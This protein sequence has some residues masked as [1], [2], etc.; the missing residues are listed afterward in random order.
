MTEQGLILVTGGF[1]CFAQSP[2]TPSGDWSFVTGA[3]DRLRSEHL[4]TDRKIETL[5]PDPNSEPARTVRFSEGTVVTLKGRSLQS[6]R[7]KLVGSVDT[8]V[9]IEG[10]RGTR[11]IIDLALALEKP[12]LPL[13]FTGG[14]ALL[15]WNENRKLIHEW[16]EIDKA[17]AETWEKLSLPGL[18]RNQ[19][20]ELAK[21]V[22]HR[23]LHQL[24]RKC[25]IM[26]P[27]ASEF[28]PVYQEAIKPAVEGIGFLPIRTD[29]IDLVGDVVGALHS[30]IRSSACAIAVITGNNANVMY[31]LGLAHA[32]A[33]PV[34]LICE[35]EAGG[36][37]LPELPYDLRHESVI[38]YSNSEL[39]TLRATIRSVLEQL[40]AH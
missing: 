36:S 7:F 19:L 35:M 29:Q 16:F 23:L 27:F 20:Y 28:F 8:L 22:K 15:R 14:V 40:K 9:A 21:S 31:E 39:P 24:R 5:L 37:G 11:E 1:K 38:A 10:A 2:E 17:T 26:M 4:S 30:A 34:V 12:V 18:S 3:R 25:F 33:K 13:P 32:Q 6:R